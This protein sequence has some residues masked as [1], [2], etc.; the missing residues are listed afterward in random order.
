M[1]QALERKLEMVLGDISEPRF[2]G[3]RDRLSRCTVRPVQDR[4]YVVVGPCRRLTFRYPP[5]MPQQ[6]KG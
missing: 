4:R 6:H 2:R 5:V 1:C 3:R